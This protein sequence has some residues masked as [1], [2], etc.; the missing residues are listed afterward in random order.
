MRFLQSSMATVNT[1]AA[2]PV[3]LP[4]RI[5]HKSGPSAPVPSVQPND[6]AHLLR[7]TFR[8]AYV[9]TLMDVTRSLYIKDWHQPGHKAGCYRYT[10]YYSCSRLFI[11][12]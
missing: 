3:V 10:L 5:I 12:F 6:V 9:Q 8:M 4:Q 11:S 1:P 2:A 7:H